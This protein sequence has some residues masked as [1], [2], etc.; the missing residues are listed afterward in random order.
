MSSRI[1]VTV[2]KDL[3]DRLNA[4][5]GDTG[6]TTDIVRTALVRLAAHG[7]RKTTR[8]IKQNN[9]DLIGR[10]VKLSVPWKGDRFK[11]VR[12]D[13]TPDEKDL[14]NWHFKRVARSIK[15]S[16]QFNKK[17]QLTKKRR[18]YVALAIINYLSMLN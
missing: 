17:K 15:T 8:A 2:N 1:F 5:T 6:W 7:E 13:V 9:D 12:L 4:T 11:T 16:N 18:I 3:L 14:I 10:A